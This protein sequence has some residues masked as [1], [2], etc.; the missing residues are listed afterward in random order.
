MRAW[1]QKRLE[2]NP[3]YVLDEMCGQLECELY[4]LLPQT[5]YGY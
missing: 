1:V 5:G 3:D 4:E 2:A